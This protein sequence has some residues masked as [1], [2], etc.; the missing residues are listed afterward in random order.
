MKRIS[1][2]L[3][4]TGLFA[5][6]SEENTDYIPTEE[7]E[8]NSSIQELKM[9]EPEYIFGFQGQNRY[10]YCPSALLQD[11][12]TIQMYF[13]GNPTVDVMIDNIYHITI[14][15][16]GAKTQ[17]VSV[18]QPGA[19]GAWDDHHTCDPSVIQ[20]EFK[21]SGVL[22]QYAMF[23]LGNSNKAYYNEIGVAF[24]NDL[25]ANSWV[26]YPRQFITKAWKGDEDQQLGGG[27]KSW[28]VG[29]PSAVSLNKKGSVLLTYTCGD[30]G[31]TNVLW[32]KINMS[33][34]DNV[35]MTTPQR[36]VTKGIVAVDNTT[37]DYLRNVDF[38]INQSEDKIVM[39]RSLSSSINSYPT[40]IDAYQEIDCMNL[41]DFMANKGTWK[42][43]YRFGPEQTGF[44]RNHNSCLLRDN[45]GSIRNW[46]YPTFFFSVSKAAPDVAAQQGKY[47]EWTYHIYKGSLN[48]N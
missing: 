20:G 13:C 48:N 31:G 23:F 40:Y 15:Q 27:A 26:K 42:K 4:F 9:S 22:Y 16:D 38:A 11:D 36:V 5:G 47:A 14:G 18:L 35:S 37:Q 21:M 7:E 8:H 17:A 34:M 2:F 3:I 19:S 39:I 33:D 1:L 46:Q 10:S 12:G 29:Q 28:G 32:T 24:S 25:N 6:C 45:Y 30:A 43:I 44:P 41:S